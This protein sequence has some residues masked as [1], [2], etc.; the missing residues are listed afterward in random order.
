MHTTTLLH[1]ATRRHSRIV[2]STLLALGA[3][4]SLRA[5]APQSAATADQP[6]P[7]ENFY[8]AANRVDLVAPID[9]DAVVAGRLLNLGQPVS[10]T[11]RRLAGA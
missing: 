4:A 6:P 8:A 10:E 3:A 7:P 1:S 5:L 9:G 11:C 2:L